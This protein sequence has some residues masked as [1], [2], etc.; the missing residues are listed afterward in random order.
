M[1]YAG[2]YKQLGRLGIDA[3]I[4]GEDS[5]DGKWCADRA[6]LYQCGYLAVG[7]GDGCA[8]IQR[9][10]AWPGVQAEVDLLTGDGVAIDVD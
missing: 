9:G 1:R 4:A 8:A 5:I 10:T 6:C 3:R 2:G 7:I